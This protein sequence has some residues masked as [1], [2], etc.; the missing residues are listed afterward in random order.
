MS[1]Y[2]FNLHINLSAAKELRWAVKNSIL[3]E[4][5]LKNSQAFTV[6]KSQLGLSFLNSEFLS[7]NL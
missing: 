3:S 5:F 6:S 2:N 7:K 4:F 1:Q